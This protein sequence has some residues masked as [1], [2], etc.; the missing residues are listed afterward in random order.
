M[1]NPTSVYDQ[2]NSIAAYR[3]FLPIGISEKSTRRSILD[4]AARVEWLNLDLARAL[5]QT[6]DFHTN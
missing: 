3:G 6:A 2:Y 5:R 4:A 1:R